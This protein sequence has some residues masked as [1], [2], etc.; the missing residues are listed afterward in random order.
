MFVD[1]ISKKF[2]LK[3]YKPTNL[4]IFKGL[5][6]Y[7]V[8]RQGFFK[9]GHEF[10][11]FLFLAACVRIAAGVCWQCGGGINNEDNSIF[12]SERWQLSHT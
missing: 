12:G 9:N 2:Y 10:I 3:Y 7:E 6:A 11:K 5:A 4:T 1:G 8:K